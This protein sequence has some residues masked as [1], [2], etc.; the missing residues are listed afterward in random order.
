MTEYGNRKD[1]DGTWAIWDED[2]FQFFAREMSTFKQ[3]FM[4][5][6]FSASS[7]H[8]FA[9]PE[10]YIEKFPEEGNH[11]L[12]KC[13]RYTDFSLRHFFEMVQKQTWYENTLFVIT[14][15]HTNG[16]TRPEY[17]NDAGA[18]KIPIIFFTPN[19]TLRGKIDKTAQQIDIMPT[20]LGFLNY[21]K[22]FVAFGKNLLDTT[23]FHNDAIMYNN[24]LFQYINDNYLY[25]FDGQNILAIYDIAND[26]FLKNNLVGKIEVK[27]EVENRLKAYIQQYT[28]RM[29][30]NQLT[31]N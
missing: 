19:G 8:P 28:T 22:T 4:T 9:V 2:F 14:A 23:K 5:A 30:D 16:L 21:D 18:Y 25:Q 13:I 1:F 29:I 6:L 10:K 17:L 26:V 24:P 31:L 3:P 7:H 11:Q 12:H 27:I 20:V 15:D